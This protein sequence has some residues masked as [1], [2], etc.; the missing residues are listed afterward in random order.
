MLCVYHV[1]CNIFDVP[2]NV[3]VYK[4]L[5]DNLQI[6][7]V[8]RFCFT[9]EK[10]CRI[11]NLCWDEILFPFVFNMLMCSA[12][13]A[14][15]SSCYFMLMGPLGGLEPLQSAIDCSVYAQ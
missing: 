10:M 9:L 15:M 4:P 11:K 12:G 6:L 5:M 3:C 1:H 13:S 8:K 2:A 7:I 14:G